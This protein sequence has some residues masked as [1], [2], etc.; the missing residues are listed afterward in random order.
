M[1]T[2]PPPARSVPHTQVHTYLRRALEHIQD[3]VVIALMLLLV[4]VSGQ[5]LWHLALMAFRDA[6]AT[7]EVL[8]QVVLVL[9][10]TEL[11]RLLIYYLRE[12]RI[13]VALAVE[14]AIVSV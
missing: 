6:I 5:A 3:G 13:S 12:H 11:Y 8:S 9:I 10:L 4:G 1:S 14:V 7:R 2:P